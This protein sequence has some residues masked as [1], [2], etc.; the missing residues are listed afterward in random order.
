ML[1]SSI[2]FLYFFLPAVLIC[3]FAAPKKLK[4]AVLLLFSLVFYAWGEPIYVLI[5]LFSTVVD[6]VHGQLVERFRGTWKARAALI[7]SVSINL[8]L[9]CFFKYTGLVP[10]PIGISFYTF[11]TMSYTIDVF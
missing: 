5:M 3:Y 9:L 10:L 2:P 7:S 11:Q 1:F 6:Y 4:N 8:G